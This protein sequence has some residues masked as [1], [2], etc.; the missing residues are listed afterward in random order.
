MEF[1]QLEYFK[2]VAEEGKLT[3]AAKKLFISAPALSASISRLEG[4]LGVRL[5]DRTGKSILLNNQG[6]IFLNA[7][8]HVF[9]TLRIAKAE[10]T[11]NVAEEEGHLTIAA[12]STNIWLDLICAFTL[13]YPNVNISHSSV[14]LS[15]LQN[16]EM[17][18]NVNFLLAAEGD[19]ENDREMESTVLF[20]DRLALM[21]HRSN[22]LAALE[23]TGIDL[24]EILS[25][26]LFAPMPD[27]SLRRILDLHF[28]M[29]GQRP[30]NLTEC[31]YMVRRSMVFS[32]R[33]LSVS[34]MRAKLTQPEPDIVYVPV[35]NPDYT[36]KQLLYRRKNAAP[37]PSE[38]LFED[39][40]TQFYQ[41]GEKSAFSFPSPGK[42]KMKG[43]KQP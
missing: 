23:N 10:M 15:S 5:F 31:S 22:R 12:T 21:V 18:S 42:N 19:V 1:L 14:F 40:S 2:A 3:S 43:E 9:S 25:E 17:P 39:F 38:S 24:N 20:S 29:I 8:N 7:V 37:R 13:E 27:Q 4:E 11:K 32:N 16:G 34:T 41:S 36:W 26:P 30:K 28:Q 35:K 6:R 33:G